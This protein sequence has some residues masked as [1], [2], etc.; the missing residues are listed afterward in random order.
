MSKSQIASGPIQVLMAAIM[1][2]GAAFAAEVPPAADPVPSKEVR[3]KMAAAHEA[4][5]ACLRS[6]KSVA[7][8]RN[9]MQTTC[10]KMHGDG[11]MMMSMGMHDHMQK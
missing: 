5:A 10:R 9:E 6:D 7:D 3:A 11:C 4:M 2:A 8:C 1:F